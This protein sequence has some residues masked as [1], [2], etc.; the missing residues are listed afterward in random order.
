MLDLEELERLADARE[1]VRRLLHG[2]DDAPTTAI[3]DSIY[4]FNNLA[5]S[6]DLSPV[7]EALEEL[8]FL[9]PEVLAFAVAMEKELRSKDGIYGGNSWKKDQ[10]EE[11]LAKLIDHAEHLGD[12]AED[13]RASRFSSDPFD[14]THGM[15]TDSCFEQALHVGNYSMMI[16]DVCGGLKLKEPTND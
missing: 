8:A 3:A 12:Q 4:A 13:A 6:T 7:I 14:I 1:E 15:A 5:F 10:P 16:A 9:R 2:K 11:L